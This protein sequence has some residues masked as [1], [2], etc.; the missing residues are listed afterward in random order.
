MTCHVIQP[1]ANEGHFYVTPHTFLWLVG[2]KFFVMQ[3]ITQS[4][5]KFYL[6]VTS[7]MRDVQECVKCLILEF[8][9][10]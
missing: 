2:W 1:A 5:L 10:M 8:E 4:S 3:W 6:H 9:Y 7:T